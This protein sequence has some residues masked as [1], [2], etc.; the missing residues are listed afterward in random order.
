MSKAFHDRMF[1]FID[2]SKPSIDPRCPS[3]TGMEKRAVTVI[4]VELVPVHSVE[5]DGLAVVEHVAVDQCPLPESELCGL[6]LD[7]LPIW[8]AQDDHHDVKAWGLC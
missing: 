4:G 7:D 6:A 2:P 3:N 8:V 1:F 5:H